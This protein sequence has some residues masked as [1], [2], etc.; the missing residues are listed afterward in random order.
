MSHHERCKSICCEQGKTTV[1]QSYCKGIALVCRV[2]SSTFYQL[3]PTANL[4]PFPTAPPPSDKLTAIRFT[5]L[6]IGNTRRQ[7]LQQS[8]RKLHSMKL[9]FVPSLSC[10]LRE[11]TYI[12]PGLRAHKSLLNSQVML[13]RTG[14]QLLLHSLASLSLAA[15]T[16]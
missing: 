1:P 9:L 10:A 12:H 14:W 2:G 15:D 7:R 11:S 4:L 3:Y 6:L 8:C 13:S 16:H 5:G